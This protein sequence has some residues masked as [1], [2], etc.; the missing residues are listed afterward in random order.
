M[1]AGIRK[2]WRPSPARKHCA[3]SRDLR[4]WDLP[5]WVDSAH[6][7]VARTL[8]FALVE[9]TLV[10]IVYGIAPL[11]VT[12]LGGGPDGGVLHGIWAGFA[13]GAVAG[14]FLGFLVP[15]RHR[16]RALAVRWP[17][18]R[19]LLTLG[20]LIA[21]VVVT[22]AITLPGSLEG[23]VAAVAIAA[24]VLLGFQV[25]AVLSTQLADSSS[26]T[27]IAV[28][29]VDLRV[30]IVVAAVTAVVWAVADA[31]G[32]DPSSSGPL[33]YIADQAGAALP[34]ACLIATVALLAVS[35]VP[36]VKVT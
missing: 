18:T 1:R 19:E 31:V 20:V 26:A 3:R 32:F 33:S 13:H 23:A 8:G 22:S 17:S 25:R 10:A 11:I 27:A 5:G 4:W 14:F 15:A 2:P 24:V 34:F 28:Y 6:L 36:Q 9:R 16:P 12:G 21:I 35:I 29:R 7:R 30:G